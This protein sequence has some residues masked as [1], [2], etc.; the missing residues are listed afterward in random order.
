MYLLFVLIQTAPGWFLME[1]FPFF[2]TESTPEISSTV[3]D[4]V[5]L[6]PRFSSSILCSEQRNQPIRSTSGSGKRRHQSCLRQIVARDDTTRGFVRLIDAL[7]RPLRLSGHQGFSNI[8]RTVLNGLS[9]QQLVSA[10][11]QQRHRVVPLWLFLVSGP[12][13]AFSLLCVHGLWQET[14]AAEGV[15]GRV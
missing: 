1:C 15:V 3:G 13:A 2:R 11:A 4:H 7:P 12:V 9:L 8:E 5:L 6:S 10:S 14:R